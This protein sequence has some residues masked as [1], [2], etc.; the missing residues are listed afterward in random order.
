MSDDFTEINKFDQHKRE[1]NNKLL[2]LEKKKIKLI[3]QL[4]ASNEELVDASKAVIPAVKD[5][6]KDSKTKL[7][8][9]NGDIKSL[10]KDIKTVEYIIK[11]L[12]YEGEDEAIN[13][14]ISE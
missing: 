11:I 14:F 10:K 6:I 13:N 4:K 5:K 1:L 8:G 2:Q 7:K 9:I 12:S 3:T